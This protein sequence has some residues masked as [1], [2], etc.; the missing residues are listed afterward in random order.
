[1]RA[2]TTR[3]MP[4]QLRK[5][6]PTLHAPTRLLTRLTRT[7]SDWL[8]KGDQ[9]WQLTAATLVAMQSIPGLVAIYSGLVKKVRNEF[10]G[11]CSTLG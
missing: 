5:Q 4:I 3:T 7:D 11:R 2:V 1:M 9:A 8:D 10:S 6:L